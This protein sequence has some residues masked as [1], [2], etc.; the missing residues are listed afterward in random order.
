MMTSCGWPPS[1]VDDPLPNATATW[2]V[3]TGFAGAAHFA[4][5]HVPVGVGL[6]QPYQPA[7]RR[8]RDHVR[9]AVRYTLADLPSTVRLS[10]WFA[11]NDRTLRVYADGWSAGKAD[12]FDW[13]LRPSIAQPRRPWRHVYARWHSFAVDPDEAGDAVGDL[14]RHWLRLRDAP[15]SLAWDQPAAQVAVRAARGAACQAL[16]V[17]SRIVKGPDSA[18]TQK[19]VA[20]FVGDLGMQPTRLAVQTMKHV[21]LTM[22]L[23]DLPDDGEFERRRKAEARVQSRAWRPLAETWADTAG[24]TE[25]PEDLVV[26]QL[27]AFAADLKNCT[28]DPRIT[29]VLSFLSIEDRV[30][31]LAKAHYSLTWEEAAV[32]CGRDAR[33]GV[34]I[35]HKVNERKHQVLARQAARTV[36]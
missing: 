12:L 35:K 11:S 28:W 22:P 23:G 13:L 4:D 9:G 10:G 26:E 24:S 17:R 18:E 7:W 31:V 3:R 29:S 14:I 27:T 32:A 25:S 16:T 30:V 6:F 8:N 5:D 21:L 36:A 1:L 19:A 33:D 34:R 15:A 20:E 2:L